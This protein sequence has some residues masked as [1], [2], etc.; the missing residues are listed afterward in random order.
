[1]SNILLFINIFHIYLSHLIPTVPPFSNREID[2]LRT[3]IQAGGI[4]YHAI[5]PC[6]YLDE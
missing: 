1:M 2:S 4:L 5:A 3:S 6:L